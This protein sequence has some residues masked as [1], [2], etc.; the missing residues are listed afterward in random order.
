MHIFAYW[1]GASRFQFV[2]DLESWT[3]AKETRS[4]RASRLD[5]PIADADFCSSPCLTHAMGIL[6]AGMAILH[7]EAQRV[8]A[9][10]GWGG[11][12]RDLMAGRVAVARA[13]TIC[14]PHDSN[15]STL[16]LGMQGSEILSSVPL[17][18]IPSSS[19]IV[20]FW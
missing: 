13:A 4:R 16:P 9:R 19:V 6:H 20:C 11:W 14:S 1:S 18:P 2:L 5:R 12:S 10:G 7:A 8:L 15:P 3:G 17:A